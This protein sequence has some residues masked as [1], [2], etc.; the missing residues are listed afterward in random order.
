MSQKFLIGLVNPLPNS[1]INQ[2]FLIHNVIL[3][4]TMHF[5]SENESEIS[6]RSRKP[7]AQF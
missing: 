2:K 3:L 4:Y 7:L 6:D 5:K 1:N